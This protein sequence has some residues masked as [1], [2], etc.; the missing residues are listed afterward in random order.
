MRSRSPVSW[1]PVLALLAGV[2]QAAP[3]ATV[4]ETVTQ[5]ETYTLLIET[6]LIQPTTVTIVEGCASSAYSP[7]GSPSVQPTPIFSTSRSPATSGEPSSG[8]VSSSA[9]R[10][11]V[12][13]PTSSAIFTD[14]GGSSAHESPSSTHAVSSSGV[15][16]SRASSS[17]A[18]SISSQTSFAPSTSSSAPPACSTGV[19]QSRAGQSYRHPFTS[20]TNARRRVQAERHPSRSAV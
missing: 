16:T 8:A 20:H 1:F 2:A 11:S 15:S 9:P 12:A 18:A 4:T 13:A 7:G 17:A 19:L 5:I 6:I 3:A 14:A 10:S